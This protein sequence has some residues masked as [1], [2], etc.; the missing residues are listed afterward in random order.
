MPEFEI[1]GTI[2]S[3][4]LR[5]EGTPI[6]PFYADE[7]RGEVILH[8]PY[9]DALKDIEGFERVWLVYWSHLVFGW[10]PLVVPFRDTRVHG[11]F[12][13]R[14]P[15][16]PN[17]IGISTVKLLGRSGR[18]LEVE[19][20]DVVD[21]TPLLDIKPY[22]AKFDAYPEANPGWFASSDGSCT[23]ADGRFCSPEERKG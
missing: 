12:A 5:P 9:L 20:I 23:V 8:E 13:T 4:F 10:E 3:P 15:G 16:R 19:G 11:T 7:A 17:P 22:V 21:G 6:Q 14:V 2:R 1:I 18:S